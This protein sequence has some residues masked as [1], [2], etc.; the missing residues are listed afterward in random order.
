MAYYF[1]G[2]ASV[3]KRLEWF[4]QKKFKIAVVIVSEEYSDPSQTAHMK[5]FVKIV[6]GLNPFAVFAK[7]SLLDAW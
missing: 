1:I 6:N 4:R 2:L 5:L 3:K 7:Y